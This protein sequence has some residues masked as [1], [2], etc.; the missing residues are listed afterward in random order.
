[1]ST[2]AKHPQAS[3]KAP[4]KSYAK[5]GVPPSKMEKKKRKKAKRHIFQE[6]SKM[7]AKELKEHG[8]RPT[9]EF[10]KVT[11]L[12]FYENA[13]E[14]CKESASTSV[15]FGRQ[16]LKGDDVVMTACRDLS[17]GVTNFLEKNYKRNKSVL[18]E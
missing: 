16:T 6:V 10:L 1:M 18:L 9:Q 5:K 13:L 15:R 3:M 4:R 14:L 2:A 8:Y 11:R 17:T 7:I 12:F